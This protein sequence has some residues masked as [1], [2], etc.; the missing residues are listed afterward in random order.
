MKQSIVFIS[1]FNLRF[2]SYYNIYDKKSVS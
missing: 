2:D 1:S